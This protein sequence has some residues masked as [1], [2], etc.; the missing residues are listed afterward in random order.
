MLPEPEVKEEKSAAKEILSGLGKMFGAG[1]GDKDKA[2]S[3]KDTTSAKDS[4]KAGAATASQ[5]TK[6]SKK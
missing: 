2:K 4:A 6:S 5:S 3:E 1:G